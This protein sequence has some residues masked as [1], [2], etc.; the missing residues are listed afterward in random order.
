MTTTQATPDVSEELRSALSSVEKQFGKGTL[1]QLGGSGPNDQVPSI[2]TGSIAFDKALGVGG[3]AAGRVA[4]V[5]GP[6]G[7]GK[8]T[9]AYHLIASCQAEGGTCAFIDAEHSMDPAYA[10]RLGVNTNDLW[11]CQPDSGEQALQVV[12]EL[13]D[14]AVQLI[15]VDS[16]A[17]LVPQAELDGNM[18]DMQ[19]GAQARLMSKAMRKLTGTLA[20]SGTTLL[21]TNQLREKVA[22]GGYGPSE[23]QPG[24][25]ALKFYSSQRLDLR[26]IKTLKRGEERYGSRIRLRAVKNKVAPPFGEGEVD[27]IWGEGFDAAGELLDLGEKAGLI[28]RSGAHYKLAADDRKLGQGREQARQELLADPLLYE[29][30]R[31]QLTAFEA[32]AEAVTADDLSAA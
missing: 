6:E 29:Q 19:V 20:R 27:I 31:Q 11:V 10:Q 9:L 23:T 12:Q 4:E 16:V 18:D 30:L 5:Y 26:R 2:P 1:M 24:G 3:L 25:R 28:K 32:P 14:G 15:I 17:A 21:F 7:S 22:N 13:S 8:T